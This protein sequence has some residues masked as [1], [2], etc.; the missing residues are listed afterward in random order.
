MPIKRGARGASRTRDR[1]VH[2]HHRR[3]LGGA[4]GLRPAAGSSAP[5]RGPRA[6]G[7]A[8]EAGCP[9]PRP[10]VFKARSKAA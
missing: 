5:S 3:L 10:V 4:P 6:G 7:P 8:A 9:A 2:G 1:E